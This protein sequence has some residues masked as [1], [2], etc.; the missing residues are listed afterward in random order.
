MLT[1]FSENVSAARA[2]G[3]VTAMAAT[4]AIGSMARIIISPSCDR[5]GS[6]LYDVAHEPARIPIGRVGLRFVIAV[7]ASDH[8]H[9]VSPI[10]HSESD[11]PLAKP[12]LALIGAE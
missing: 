11:L 4:T 9:M 8:E 10:R 12:V 6:L 5:N 3:G 7:C 1:D 2:L